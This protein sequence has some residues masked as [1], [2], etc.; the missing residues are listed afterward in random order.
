MRRKQRSVEREAFSLATKGGERHSMGKNR[1][2]CKSQR[3][4]Y[5]DEKKQSQKQIPVI[6]CRK[7]K[8]VEW[9]VFFIS[10]EGEREVSQV[11]RRIRCEKGKGITTWEQRGGEVKRRAERINITEPVQRYA[12]TPGYKWKRGEGREGGYLYFIWLYK[13][14]A[15]DSI[16]NSRGIIPGRSMEDNRYK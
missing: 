7:T 6:E 3:G 5:N 13:G 9:Q 16:H 15:K 14:Q 2:K 10:H 1:S 12:L 4:K 8:G 11:L